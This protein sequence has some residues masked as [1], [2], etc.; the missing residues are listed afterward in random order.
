M[1]QE[2]TRDT[3]RLRYIILETFIRNVFVNFFPM[4]TEMSKFI[5]ISLLICGIL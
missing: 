4:N 1:S 2:N 3:N 5:I